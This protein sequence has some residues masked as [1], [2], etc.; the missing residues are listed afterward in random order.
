MEGGAGSAK[1]FLRAPG[2]EDVGRLKA[3]GIDELLVG[4]EQSCR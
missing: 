3:G 1:L 4:T 2:H